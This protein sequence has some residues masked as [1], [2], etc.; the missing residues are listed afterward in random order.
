MSPQDIIDE[1]AGTNAVQITIADVPV[2]K[3]EGRCCKY[4]RSQDFSQKIGIIPTV[5][6][7]IYRVVISTCL[8]LFVPQ[9][10]DD[11]V[12]EFK[13]NLVFEN[14][15][16]TAGV[17]IN[18][19]TL[20]CFLALYFVE[21]KRENSLINYLEVS[22]NVASDN[23]S[24]GKTLELLPKDKQLSILYL[25]KCYQRGGFF[26]IFLFLTNAILSGF[27][28]SDYYLDKQTTS[29]FVTNILFIITK[30]ID[31]Y[32]VANTEENI[33]YSAYLKG[34]IQ[35]NDVDPDKQIPQITNG[36][37]V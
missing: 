9:K 3:T 8:I 25:D 17:V 15:K 21:V 12:C 14:K 33:F 16:Y 28:V 22:A 26:I 7:E 31:I 6:F 11:H 19:I 32:T 27:V 23:I 35:Y 5:A 2:P 24:V 13:E 34:R 20:A 10:C 1:P 37:V 36:N 30:L 4:I 18:F 29:T